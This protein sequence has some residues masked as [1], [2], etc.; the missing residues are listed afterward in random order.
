MDTAMVQRIRIN[1]ICLFVSALLVTHISL[2]A[3]VKVTPRVETDFTYT[4]N[5]DLTASDEQSSEVTSLIA[6]IEIQA[7][8]NDGNL[9]L[10]YQ[11]KQLLYSYN[12]DKNEL[13]NELS[14]SADKGLFSTTNIRGNVSAS[15]TNV[16]RN[17]RSNASTDVTT[18]DTV[19]SRNVD[20]GLSYQSNPSGIIDLFTSLDGSVTSNDDSVGNNNTY[21]ASVIA[22]QGSAVKTYFWSTNYNYETSVGKKDED[23]TESTEI[24]QELGLQQIHGVSSYLHLYYEDYNGQTGN[25]SAD[26]SSWGPGIKYYFNRRSY[27]DI[28]YDFSLSNDNSDFL[29]GGLHLNPS[30]RTVLDFNYTKRFYGDAYSFSLTHGTKRITNSITYEE[31]VSNYNRDLYISGNQIEQLSISKTLSWTS[32]LALRRSTFNLDLSSEKQQSFSG[33]LQN[34]DVDTYSGELS[35][36][37]NLTRSTTVSPGFSYKY[38]DFS[39]MGQ[40]IQQD[41]YR[42]WNLDLTHDFAHDLSMQF[43]LSYEDRSSTESSVEYQ[44]SRVNINIR[45]EL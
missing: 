8:G 14:L 39:S 24:N 35:I 11:I 2:A 38:Y 26:S 1:R 41:Y 9:S 32:S 10:D 28:G 29:R 34:T 22:K 23:R 16:A 45:K 17:I 12:S 42:K 31:E 19:E 27:V 18:A 6:G 4:D 21:N 3:D 5:V 25:D 20:I 33:I 40:T 37:H 30:A 36:D 15:I 43:G 13:Y 44:E 7:D